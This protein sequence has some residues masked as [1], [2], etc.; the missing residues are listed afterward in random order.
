MDA[1][2]RGEVKRCLLALLIGGLSGAPALAQGTAV[3]CRAARVA[4]LAIDSAQ[5]LTDLSVLA[6]DSMEGR[7]FGTAGGARARAYLLRRMRSIG[8]D[9]FPAGALQEVRAR[10]LQ[11]TGANVIGYVRGT[12]GG[13][14]TI[15]ITA[16]YDHLGVQ[17]GEVYNGADDN[18]S[19]TAALLA[20][21]AWFRAHAPRHHLLFVAM[22]G[23]ELGLLGARRFVEASPVPLSDI[24]L[25]LNFDMVGRNERGELQVV[26]PGHRPTLLP[27]VERASCA[28]E[29]RLMLGHDTGASRRDDWT[30]QSDHA[31]FHANDIPFLYFGVEDHPDYH[32]ATDEVERIDAGFFVRATRTLAAVVVAVDGMEGGLE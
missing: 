20:L 2:T 27:L 22:D 15:V 8:L 1:W 30:S 29:V 13:R 19:G 11:A 26:G 4:P 24:R 23:E 7:G 21:A 3:E 12:S 28:A 25:N 16:H 17:E 9:T 32:R 10:G 18:A 5:L 14:E 6:A 31:L